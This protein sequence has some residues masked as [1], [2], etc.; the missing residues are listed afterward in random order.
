[1]MDTSVAELG[2]QFLDRWVEGMRRWAPWVVVVALSAT[3]GAAVFVV[4]NVS[5]NTDTEE[6]LSPDLPFQKYSREED[7]AFPQLSDTLVVVVDGQTPDLAD[8]AAVALAGEMR[9]RPEFFRSIYDPAADAFFRRNGLLY[10]STDELYALS[11]RL[12]E[13][14][15]FLG[16]LWHD[17]SLRGLFD[18]LGLAI[19]ASLETKDVAPPI[20]IGRVLA[21]V[22]ETLEA[23]QNGQFSQLSWR[24]LM[25]A[26]DR[27]GGPYRRFIL[28]QP[29]LDFGSLQPATAAIDTVRS[30]AQGLGLTPDRG[31]RVRLTGSAAMAEDELKSVE[32]GMGVAALVS[33]VLVG[34][35]LLLA[36][37]SVRLALA[38]L[39]TLAMGLV[40]TAA[41][42]T[43]AIGRLNLISV[44][45]AV[46]FIG[47]SVDFG[48]HFGLR[49]REAVREGGGSGP[50]LRKAAASVGG[51]LA[52]CAVAAAIGF[53]SFL[54]TAYLGL[55]ELGLIAGAGMFIAL[56]SNLTI[57]PALLA[58]MPVRAHDAA[59]GGRGLGNPAAGWLAGYPRA[60][61]SG[62]LLLAV[63]ASLMLP[64]ARFDFDP[65]N[66]RDPET[67][68]VA[69]Y[70]D[71]VEDDADGPYSVTILAKDVAE[72]RTLGESLSRLPEVRETRSIADY[73]PAEQDTKLDII[74]TMALFLA[75][76]LSPGNQQ[77]PPS[78]SDNRQ[79][80]S[81]LLDRLNALA[82]R[83]VDGGLNDSVERLADAINALGGRGAV[84]VVIA[85]MQERL[86]AGLPIRLEQLRQALMADRVTL[87]SLPG[88]L[89]DREIAAD[90]R[91]RLEVYPRENLTDREALRRF[92]KSVRTVAP[93]ATGGPIIILEAGDAVVA[94]F[95]EAGLIAVSCI[96][97]LLFVVLRNIRDVLFVFAPLVLATLL[98]I[99]ASV[100]LALPFNFANVIVLPLLFGLGVANGIHVIS[101]ARHEAGRRDVS[102]TSTP[103]AVMFSALTTIG[104]FGTIALSS[105]PG[106]ASMGILLTV[107]L[108]ITLLC[109]L[110]L[111]PALMA[112]PLAAWRVGARIR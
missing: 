40:W 76:A 17:P 9:Q 59:G 103:R 15:P 43:L 104:S 78:V 35:L 20:E 57:L 19:D 42:A 81:G 29:V 4:R 41:F 39:V 106:T 71:L 89:R 105:H 22:A 82:E 83:D 24:Q 16:A 56:F 55:A 54:P 25:M 8:D 28:V 50:A 111:L 7:E 73:I 63:L 32:E 44:A 79:A 75:P 70:L 18:I 33:M 77:T 88:D 68:S 98:T 101:R 65:L 51:A 109:T 38:T 72:A 100:L 23:Q 36:F 69:T 102:A 84:D 49:Y 31:V 2:R 26:D 85:D 5:I 12:A 53:F 13:A 92:V 62:A 97:A 27:E 6:M 90:G 1:M 10:L 94:A 30:L 46:L 48:I 14:Q 3:L 108:S 34:A 58:L 86:L 112:L 45:F 11:D 60:V 96:S 74:G 21:A 67:E 110:V 61:L 64:R 87:Q 52:L 37:R 93:H 47:L 80:L 91:T 107:A 95:R 66:L 99:A